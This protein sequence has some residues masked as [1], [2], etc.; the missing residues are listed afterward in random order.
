M[1]VRTLLIQK[2]PE[3]R[4]Q[5]KMWKTGHMTLA[6]PKPKLGKSTITC[7]TLSVLHSV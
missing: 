6:L 2:Q 1:V 7:H 3:P 4:V 5:Y